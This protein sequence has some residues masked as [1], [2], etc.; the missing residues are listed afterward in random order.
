MPLDSPRG[1]MYESFHSGEECH[2]HHFLGAHPERKDSDDIWVFSVYAPNARD[3]S[4]ICSWNPETPCPMQ[5]V[6]SGIYKVR[7]PVPALPDRTA[8]EYFFRI[9]T[10]LGNWRDVPD[11]YSTQMA[12]G[13]RISAGLPSPSSYMWMDDEWMAGRG[14]QT[15]VSEPL[16]IYELHLPTW[17]QHHFPSGWTDG[18]LNQPD[19]VDQL[20]AWVRDMGYTHVECMPVMSHENLEG[21]GYLIDSFFSVAQRYGTADSLRFMIDRFHQ[22]GIGVILDWVPAYFPDHPGWMA[23]FDGNPVFESVDPRRSGMPAWHARLFDLSRP[24]TRSFLLSVAHYWLES[25]HADGL[26]MNAVSAMLYHDVCR[27]GDNWTPN[28]YGGR[29]NLEGIDFIRYLNDT[30]RR[31]FPDCLLIAE[32]SQAF[33]GVTHPTSENGLG[34]HLK[35]NTGW[36]T[37]IL[38]YL[39]TEEK[40]RKW[41]HDKLTFSL[42]YAFSEH[43]ILPLS[44]ETQSNVRLQ[45]YLHSPGDPRFKL[46]MLRAVFAYSI[47]H[48]GKK[49]LYIGRE[50]LKDI[51]GDGISMDGMQR[52]IRD[53]NQIYLSERPLYEIDDSWNGF[54]WTQ[55]NDSGNSIVSFL[56]WD[57][58]GCAVLAIT[59]FTSVN[60]PEY[61]VPFPVGG[62]LQPL[63]SSDSVQYGGESKPDD[64]ELEVQKFAWGDSGWSVGLTVPAFST[65][66]YRFL[67]YKRD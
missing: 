46:S 61:R 28:Q 47:A 27:S 63:F 3:V 37:D 38:S 26:R 6:G 19:A 1:N 41:Q 12:C 29:E 43:F 20:V 60:Y 24:E 35:W 50:Y 30:L 54:Q 65:Q 62:V 44:H 5:H 49:L 23:D 56:R 34:F 25:F 13:K 57:R 52:C 7:V 10:A 22:A 59:N 9:R 4:L 42:Y 16:N 14:K 39:N 45:D 18:G 58:N 36:I 31:S 66:F 21:H 48:P 32:E 40:D 67:R 2:A 55:A 15:S 8:A 33:P 53:L 17:F 11:P 51:T 64:R